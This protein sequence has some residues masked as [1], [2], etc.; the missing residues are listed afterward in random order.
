M[1]S[2]AFNLLQIIIF[3]YL[4]EGNYSSSFLTCGRVGDQSSESGKF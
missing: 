3:S 1:N 2:T 4:Q